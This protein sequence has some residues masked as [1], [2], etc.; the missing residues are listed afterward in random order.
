ME[1]NDFVVIGNV[2]CSTEEGRAMVID[3]LRGVLQR[4]ARLLETLSELSV[5]SEKRKREASAL[6]KAKAMH[7]AGLSLDDVTIAG[8]GFKVEDG[9]VVKDDSIPF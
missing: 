4:A 6:E 1:D 9:E 5:E 3:E 7:A 2:T 8:G